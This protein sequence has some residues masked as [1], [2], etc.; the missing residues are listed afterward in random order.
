MAK[1]PS[2][3]FV[4]TGNTCRS[5]M[6]EHLCRHLSQG[7]IETASAGIAANPHYPI[8]TAVSRLLGAEGVK[9]FRHV[10]SMLQ[11]SHLDN[12]DYVFVMEEAHREEILAR[13]PQ[14]R[15]KIHLL[16]EFALGNQSKE[17]KEI[18]FGVPDPIGGSMDVYETCF[19]EIKKCIK[20]ILGR[21]NHV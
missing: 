6:A 13:F 8:P 14:A 16:K 18:P 21:L 10:P 2:L 12:A 1:K 7:K 3:L 5:V 11:A 17:N 4:C 19:N 15:P 9:N 20:E